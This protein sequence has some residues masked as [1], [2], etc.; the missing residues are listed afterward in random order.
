MTDTFLSV[1]HRRLAALLRPVTPGFDDSDPPTIETLERAFARAAFSTLIEPGDPAANALI[2]ALGVRTALRALVDEWSP[3]EV[4][5]RVRAAPPEGETETDARGRSAGD[6]FA[7]TEGR[8]ALSGDVALTSGV[9]RTS[10]VAGIGAGGLGAGGLGVAHDSHAVAREKHA[11]AGDGST[12]DTTTGGGL[13]IADDRPAIVGDGAA[14]G[15]GRYAFASDDHPL[16]AEASSANAALNPPDGP[17]ASADT[18]AS[19]DHPLLARIEEAFARWRPRLSLAAA[20]RSLE[21][22]AKVRAWFLTPEHGLWPSRL[23]A[24]GESE[25]VALWIRGDPERLA[26]LERSLS[27]VGARAATGYGEHVATESAAGLSDRG[28]AIVSGGAYGIDGAAHR[29]ALVS[30]QVTVAF[31]AGGVD[32][33]YPAGHSDLLRRVPE[34]GLLI[35]ELPCGSTPTRWRFLS[36]NRLIA[37]AS[38][39]TIV[40]EAGRRSGSLNTAGHAAELGRPLGAV[41]GPVTSPASAGCHRLI[42]DYAAT[43]VTTVEEMA[44]LAEPIGIGLAEEHRRSGRERHPRSP[45]ARLLTVLSTRRPHGSEELA[46]LAGLSH[47]DVAAALGRLELEGLA[48]EEGSGWV[49]MS[50]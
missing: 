35:G 46:A 38:S 27:L 32:R 41:P 34:H 36:R 39:A 15:G 4:L 30:G 22:A 2:T 45:D 40:I 50:G 48:R 19:E 5:E 42:R 25:P 47:R 1:P 28:F 8:P 18:P 23:E 10:G 31:L 9:A 24:L 12:T 20:I 17:S 7:D 14:A 37:A 16:G 21:T 33:L 43:C 44:E 6:G 29:A 26:S 49:R 11:L 3:A 13:V